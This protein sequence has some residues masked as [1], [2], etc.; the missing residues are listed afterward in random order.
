[1]IISSEVQCG[2][3]QFICEPKFSQTTEIKLLLQVVRSDFLSNDLP[4]ELKPLKDYKSI[5]SKY[6]RKFAM[7]LEIVL[8]LQ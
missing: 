2:H 1:M 7:F 5:V 4:M 8:H 3:D 6:I